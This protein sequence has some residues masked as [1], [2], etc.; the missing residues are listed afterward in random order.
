[1]EEAAGPVEEEVTAVEVV[2]GRAVEVAAM[3]EEAAAAMEE[4]AYH[5]KS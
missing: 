5:K 1:M 3:E 2:A 4:V